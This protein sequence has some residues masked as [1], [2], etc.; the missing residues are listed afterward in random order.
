MAV[1]RMRP[2]GPPWRSRCRG[3]SQTGGLG[4]RTFTHLTVKAQVS[5]D[6]I[7]SDPGLCMAKLTREQIMVGAAMVERGLP[8]RQSARQ[9]GVVEGTVRYRLKQLAAG[10]RDDGRKS[11]ATP[12]D[13]KEQAVQAVLEGL[14]CWR[15]TGEGRPAQARVIYEVLLRDHGYTGSYR[16]LVRHLRRSYVRPPMR[17]YRRVE[18]PPGVQAQHDWFEARTRAGGERWEV[19][20]L[21]GVLS[22]SRAKFCWVSAEATQLAWHTGHLAAIRALCSPLVLLRGSGNDSIELGQH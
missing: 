6:E 12:L 11:K 2:Q 13:G 15:V 20:A 17:A 22:H 5:G 9:L 3:T 1:P 7:P 10:P 16:A 8:K 21:V 18:T 19:Q 4:T 14:E